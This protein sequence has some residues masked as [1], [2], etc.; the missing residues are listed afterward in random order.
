MYL[1][2]PE[3]SAYDSYNI[4]WNTGDGEPSF[5]IQDGAQKTKTVEKGE[6]WQF[7]I[8]ETTPGKYIFKSI[9]LAEI[10]PY[11][12]EVEYIE[13]NG[14]AQLN[15]GIY[16]ETANTVRFKVRL[17]SYGKNTP[18]FTAYRS[19]RRPTLRIRVDD[20][21]KEQQAAIYCGCLAGYDPKGTLVKGDAQRILEGWMDGP[22]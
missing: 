22:S 8:S 12:A 20:D 11:D 17:P 4:S 7:M 14:R 21:Y 15:T 3:D 18:V 1:E 6:K 13:S 9:K 2:V 10:L 19:E 16:P 5:L